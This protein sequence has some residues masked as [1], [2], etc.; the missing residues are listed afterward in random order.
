MVCLGEWNCSWFMFR[1]LVIGWV[2]SIVLFSVVLLNCR[3]LM[4]SDSGGIL[5]GLVLLVL[6]CICVVSSVLLGSMIG[7][8]LFGVLIGVGSDC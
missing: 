5:V 8:L 7:V 1:L 2:C 3:L 4:F 6:V